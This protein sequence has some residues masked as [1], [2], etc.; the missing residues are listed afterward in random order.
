MKFVIKFAFILPFKILFL[1]CYA[2]IVEIVLQFVI[3]AVVQAA[4]QTVIQAVLHSVV[5]TLGALFLTWLNFVPLSCTI[6]H[7]MTSLD[8][9]WQNQNLT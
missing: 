2:S 5:Q 8:K 3:Q 7:P 6:W 4:L 9:H 1:F